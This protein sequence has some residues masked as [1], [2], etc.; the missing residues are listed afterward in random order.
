MRGIQ[1]F[2]RTCH[3]KKFGLHDDDAHA[4][5]PNAFRWSRETLW[6]KKPRKTPLQL[7]S[8]TPIAHGTSGSFGNEPGAARLASINRDLQFFPSA[9]YLP[10]VC[11]CKMITVELPCQ[12]RS[13]NREILHYSCPTQL[14]R[15]EVSA[16]DVFIVQWV[17]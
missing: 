2:E 3:G 4:S 1:V 16:P 12:I 7:N 17:W 5:L 15:K 6:E 11:R 13:D 10:Q 9:S 14:A 8:N